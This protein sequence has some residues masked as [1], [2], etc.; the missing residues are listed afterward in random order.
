MIYYKKYSDQII[1]LGK[2]KEIA[3]KTIKTYN[4]SKRKI[5]SYIE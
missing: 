4:K 1:K 2:K 3:D 5:L